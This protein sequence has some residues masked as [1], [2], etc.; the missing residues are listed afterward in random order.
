ML[1]VGIRLYW[2]FVL[3]CNSPRGS[4]TGTDGCIKSWALV[5][6]SYLR[7]DDGLAPAPV[8]KSA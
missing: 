6:P 4:R 7:G 5:L 1:F 2:G 3:T 8:A